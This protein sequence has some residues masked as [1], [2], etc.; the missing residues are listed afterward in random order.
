MSATKPERK[1]KNNMTKK[2]CSEK[3]VNDLLL[4]FA[5]T[6]TAFVLTIIMFNAIAQ[7]RYGHSG[8]LAARGFMWALFGVSLALGIFFVCL[9]NNKKSKIG[10]KTTAIYSFI[11]AA[12]A[13]WFVGAEQIPFYLQKIIPFMGKFTGTY[14]VVFA[15]FPIL[16]VAVIVEFAVYFYRYYTLNKNK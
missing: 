16:A 14:K 9:Y 15:M 11:T 6:L 8:Y 12:F 10:Y 4:Q 13:F 1:T 2:Q 7:F 5:Y 3:I